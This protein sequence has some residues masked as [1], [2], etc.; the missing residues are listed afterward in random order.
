[1]SGNPPQ[2]VSMRVGFL[3]IGACAVFGSLVGIVFPF[4]ADKA[5]ILFLGKTPAGFHHIGPGE[6]LLF[7][8]TAAFF[9][10]FN[11][12][13]FSLNPSRWW[14]A[15]LV[16]T[17]PCGL[18]GGLLTFSA[19]TS[20]TRGPG[21]LVFIAIPMVITPICLFLRKEVWSRYQK[22]VLPVAKSDS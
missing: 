20:F 19:P 4:L 13:I 1:M 14:V 21:F 8:S 11:G 9:G 22:P 5:G 16:G 6:I 10:A 2:D 15:L 12:V 3:Y 7:G 17:I 18:F